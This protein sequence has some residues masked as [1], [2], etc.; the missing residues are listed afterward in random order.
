MGCDFALPSSSR[1]VTTDQQEMTQ[2]SLN[3]E[4]IVQR[5]THDPIR[6]LQCGEIVESYVRIDPDAAKK[7]P[8]EG[9]SLEKSS[10][11]GCPLVPGT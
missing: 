10:T 2:K 8:P 7:K 9:G 6:M 5:H 3:I 4:D 11:G 1:S